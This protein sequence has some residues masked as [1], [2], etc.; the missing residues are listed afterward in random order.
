MEFLANLLNNDVV[1]FVATHAVRGMILASGRSVP[2]EKPEERDPQCVK[3]TKDHEAVV[4]MVTFWC[5]L[6]INDLQYNG[7]SEESIKKISKNDARFL[8]SL[9][10]AIAT[11]GDDTGQDAWLF[12]N[13]DAKNTDYF[14]LQ[15]CDR[16]GK[17]ARAVYSIRAKQ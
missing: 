4:R 6:R 10:N 8:N 2:V 16:N 11:A 7:A 5:S 12:F 15:Y 17:V 1:K 9:T 13:G 3:L 14:E